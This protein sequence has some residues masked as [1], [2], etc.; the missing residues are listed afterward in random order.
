VGTWF[1]GSS[2]DYTWLLGCFRPADAREAELADDEESL[3]AKRHALM[4]ARAITF[5]LKEDGRCLD[6]E[7]SLSTDKPTSHHLLM[8]HEDR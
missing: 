5:K 8:P 4:I 6:H 3:Q 1:A 2:A 7:E